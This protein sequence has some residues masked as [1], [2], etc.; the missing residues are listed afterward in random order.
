MA[1]RI[2]LTPELVRQ[3]AIELSD[4]EGYAG[5]TLAAVAAR[6]NVRSPSHSAH[7]AH[8][9]ALRR[10]LALHAAAQLAESLRLARAG[11]SGGPALEAV[12]HAYLT[13][14]RAHPGWYEAVHCIA[15]ADQDTTLYRA[16][17]GM[18]MPLVTS[19][20][21]MGVPPGEV[22]HQTRVVR[23][24]LHGFASLE[25][26]N[27]FGPPVGFDASFA[28]LVELLTSGVARARERG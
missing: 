10:E 15:P 24:A 1:R 20:V 27:G 23:S 21:E 22:I 6:L 28:R 3:A 18:V 7:C 8:L 14:A 9:D 5:V 16:L 2:G 17:A 25:R 26:S 19:L 4:E 13:Y 12:S 11:L